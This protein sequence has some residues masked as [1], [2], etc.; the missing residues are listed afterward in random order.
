M[1][2]RTEIKFAIAMC[3]V[4]EGQVQFL[5]TNLKITAAAGRYEHVKLHEMWVQVAVNMTLYFF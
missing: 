3:G 2:Q 4:C 5:F 1:R